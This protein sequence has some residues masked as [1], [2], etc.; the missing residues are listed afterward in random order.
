MAALVAIGAMVS[1]VV[2]ASDWVLATVHSALLTDLVVAGLGALVRLR[3]Q[4]GR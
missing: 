4:R 2:G 3:P 1:L